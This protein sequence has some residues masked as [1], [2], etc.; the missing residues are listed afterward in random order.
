MKRQRIDEGRIS[1]HGRGLGT[2]TPEMVQKRAREIALINGRPANQVTETDLEEARRELTGADHAD[3]EVEPQLRAEVAQWEAA[4]GSAG[5]QAPT[6]PAHDE[7]TDT[8]RL[9]EEGIAEAEHDQMVEGT[10]ESMKR[11]R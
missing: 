10:K 3:P 2:P 4:A 7:Q 1:N 9:V 6:L 5:E 8:E 11:G